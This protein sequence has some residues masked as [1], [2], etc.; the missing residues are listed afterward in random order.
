MFG[1]AK[2]AEVTKSI[3]NALENGGFELLLNQLISLRSDGPHVNTTI[4]NHINK[5]NYMTNEGIHG[6]HFVQQACSAQCIS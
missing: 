1:H 5:Q 4:R 2:G 3:L 6:L